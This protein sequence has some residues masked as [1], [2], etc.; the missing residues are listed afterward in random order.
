MESVGPELT[1]ERQMFTRQSGVRGENRGVSPDTERSMNKGTE[2]SNSLA[3]VS[4]CNWFG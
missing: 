3:S 4:I 2:E 1:F